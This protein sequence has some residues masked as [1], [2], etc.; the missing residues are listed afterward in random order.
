MSRENRIEE[1]AEC[2]P[3]FWNGAC[4]VDAANPTDCDLMCKMFGFMTS[5]VNAGYRKQEWISVDERLPEA[6]GACIA[7]RFD[8][9]VYKTFFLGTFPKTITHWMPLP[10]A[11]KMK[12]GAE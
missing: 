7:C 5:L 2:C 12:G 8:G 4:T 10:E 6:K 9:Y 3:Y 11:P 1:M